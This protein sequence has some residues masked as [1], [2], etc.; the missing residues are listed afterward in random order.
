[1]TNHKLTRRQFLARA[2]AAGVGLMAMGAMPSLAAEDKRPNIVFILSDDHR[3][4]VMGHMGHPFIK[5]PNMDR[6]AREGARLVN[7]FATTALCSP[8]RASF[9]T[10]KYVHVHGVRGNQ[11]PFPTARETTFPQLLKKAGYDTAY[12]GKWHMDGQ[13]EVQPGFDRWVSFR[14]HSRYIDPPMIIDGKPTPHKGHMT[15]ILTKYAVDWLKQDHKAPF[16]L[17]LAHKAAHVLTMPSSS[18]ARKPMRMR[19]ATTAASCR[20]ST[21]ASARCSIRSRRPASSITP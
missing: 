4:N 19:S 8:S 17:Y 15:D 3:W 12:I 14:G 20:G 18:E 9:L 5:T 13:T 2:G 11:K 7:A 10:G 1:M 21:I 6:L 16:L